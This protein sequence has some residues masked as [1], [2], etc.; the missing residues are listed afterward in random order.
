ML[1][2]EHQSVQRNPIIADVFHRTSMIE[3]WGRGTN[4]VVAMCR[5][6]GVKPPEF[7]EISGAAVV[8]FRVPVGTAKPEVAREKTREKILAAIAGNPHI[9]TAQLAE[10]T[11]L[12]AKGVEWNLRNLREE[13]KIRRTGADRGGRW[14]QAAVGPA[15][16]A[17]AM[18]ETAK[19]A[20]EKTG[21]NTREKTREEILA[22]IV[23]NPR[24]T[25]AE[26]AQTAQLSAKGVEWNLRRLRVEGKVRRVGADRGGHWEVVE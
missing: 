17:G 9:T 8:T 5:E 14:E 13:G 4:R 18:L 23:G 24:I 7:A 19:K 12:S 1:T 6:V 26:L 20:R 16:P 10:A 11:H 15:M 21:E 22:V 25:V 3:K 2:R